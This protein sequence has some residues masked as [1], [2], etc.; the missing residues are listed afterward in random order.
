MATRLVEHPDHIELQTGPNSSDLS[1]WALSLAVTFVRFFPEPRL[2]R[3]WIFAV[4]ALLATVLTL[5]RRTASFYRE[6]S[7]VATR[8]FLLGLIALSP[9]TMT[10]NGVHVV[11][12]NKKRLP[13]LQ[14]IGSG[15]T[16]LMPV[17]FEILPDLVRRGVVPQAEVDQ[18]SVLSERE[19]RTNRLVGTLVLLIFFNSGGLIRAIK[20]TPAAEPRNEA[21]PAQAVPP[22]LASSPLVE[23][24]NITNPSELQCLDQTEGKG[25]NSIARLLNCAPAET[26]EYFRYGHSLDMKTAS[27]AEL[28]CVS[29]PVLYMFSA[30]RS[31]TTVDEEKFVAGEIERIGGE[32]GLSPIESQQLHDFWLEKRVD[33]SPQ[34]QV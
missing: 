23:A 30:D 26:V 33:K 22:A 9:K 7:Q 17:S 15:R 1:F 25:S 13:V 21:R 10:V 31:L 4:G 8:T 3:S 24:M 5:S 18:L 14:I 28:D 27:D 2:V 34:F 29:R 32:C 19:I 12:Q 20:R 16:V 6:P 11:Q